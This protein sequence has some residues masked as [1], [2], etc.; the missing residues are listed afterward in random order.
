MTTTSPCWSPSPPASTPGGSRTWHLA[1]GV[2]RV[3]AARAWVRQQFARLGPRLRSPSSPSCSSASSSPMPCATRSRPTDRHRAAP[4]RDR[5]PRARATPTQPLPRLRQVPTPPTRAVAACNWSRCSP[6]GGARADPRGK[7]VWRDLPLP[8]GEGRLALPF[9]VAVRAAGRR[10]GAARRPGRWPPSEHDKQVGCPRQHA[11]TPVAGG[12][13]ARCGP[14]K[15][16]MR[17]GGRRPRFLTVT[18]HGGQGRSQAGG[19]P[20][21]RP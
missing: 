12:A 9:V 8:R 3:S 16:R 18:K 7:V 15:T 4:R 20:A 1:G 21:L 14:V 5:H 6:R 2:E 19:R 17:D 10:S 13:Y 11:H